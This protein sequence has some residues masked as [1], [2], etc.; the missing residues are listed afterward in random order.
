MGLQQQMKD[1]RNEYVE[2]VKKLYIGGDTVLEIQHSLGI[3]SSRTVS[4]YLAKAQL[5]LDEKL[6]HY[7]ARYLRKSGTHTAG[8]NQHGQG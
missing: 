3:G 2:K 6:A 7:R 5:T 1:I 4:R 8:T